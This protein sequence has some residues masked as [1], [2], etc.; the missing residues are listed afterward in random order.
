MKLVVGLGNP[1]DYYRLTRHNI[2][3]LIVEKVVKE[4]NLQFSQNKFRSTI[5]E[6]VIGGQQVVI[7]KPLTYMNLCGDVAKKLLT[8]FGVDPEAMIIVHDDLDMEFGKI[9]I[10]EKG[11]H[12]GHNGI[13][14]IVTAIGTKDFLRLKVG[15]GRPTNNRSV[16]DYVLSSFDPLQSAFLPDVLHLAA[17]AVV[18]LIAQELRVAMNAFNGQ[19]AEQSKTPQ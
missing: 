10:K 1:G 9:K 2:G 18:C 15:I 8:Y 14:S 7:V 12:G 11:G 4:H 3:F 16:T 13:R 5:A 6:G 17:K 19:G